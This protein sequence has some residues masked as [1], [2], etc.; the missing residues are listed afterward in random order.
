[1][2]NDLNSLRHAWT[3][4]VRH[5]SYHVYRLDLNKCFELLSSLEKQDFE[6]KDVFAGE[7]PLAIATEWEKAVIPSGASS[8]E[9]VRIL[10]L[11]LKNG[12]ERYPGTAVFLYAHARH[13]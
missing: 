13:G 4:R 8:S 3:I 5:V 7:K 10:L 2:L 12:A 9:A 11:L 1:M 6:L